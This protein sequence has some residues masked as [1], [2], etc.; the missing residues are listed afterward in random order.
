MT[1][2]PVVRVHDLFCLYPNPAGRGFVAALRGLTLDLAGERLLVHGPNGSGKTTLLRVLTG[3]VPPSAGTVT[4]GGVDLIG[5]PA[6]DAVR[7]RSRVLGLVDQQK[8]LIPELS[9]VD[10]ITLQ[11]RLRGSAAGARERAYGL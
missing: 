3:E 10:N 9:V 6:G 2:E 11:S 5:A 8:T 1:S 7:L 4:V